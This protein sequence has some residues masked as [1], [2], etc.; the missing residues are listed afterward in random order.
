MSRTR[1]T[2]QNELTKV[3]LNVNR[4]MEDFEDSVQQLKDMNET[5]VE[6]DEQIAERE[7]TNGF[8]LTEIDKKFQDNKVRAVNQYAH[9]LG[10]TLISSEELSDLK[11]ELK[12]VKTTGQEEYD[13]QLLIQQ[14][15][16]DEKL[17]QSLSIQKLEHECQSAQLRA[18]V[19]RFQ[20]EVENMNG[21]LNRM[22]DELTSQKKLT[23][24]VAA[25]NRPAQV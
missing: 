1:K 17:L 12:R 7:R 16:L 19:D 23:G 21:T 22:S 6:L 18:E 8:K 25:M 3:L 20:K 14:S 24:E 13:A 9:E 4:R 2:Q 11:N 15:V 5:L 10:K